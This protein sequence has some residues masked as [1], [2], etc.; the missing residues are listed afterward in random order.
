MEERTLAREMGAKGAGSQ[1]PKMAG[2]ILAAEHRAATAAAAATPLIEGGGLGF[3]D[4][5]GAHEEVRVV[6]SRASSN[7][8]QR[9]SYD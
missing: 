2:V 9:G 3:R 8:V 1:G 6:G 7:A 4:G 5:G